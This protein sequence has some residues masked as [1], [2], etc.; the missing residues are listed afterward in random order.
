MD[1]MNFNTLQGGLLYWTTFGSPP[2]ETSHG[3]FCFKN[4]RQFISTLYSYGSKNYLLWIQ[5]G[6]T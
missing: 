3:V 6:L 5:L 2:S 4:N 1:E